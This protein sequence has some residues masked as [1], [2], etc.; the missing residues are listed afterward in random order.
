MNYLLDTHAFLWVIFDDQKLS[1]SAKQAIRNLKNTLY[2]STITYREIAL[3]Y[4]IGKLA[5]KT[6]HLASDQA[7]FDINLKGQKHTRLP[8]I[9][10]KH[11]VVSK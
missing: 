11:L 9:W 7:K 8:E 2:I 10:I 5:L 1:A 3:K 4:S 6:D